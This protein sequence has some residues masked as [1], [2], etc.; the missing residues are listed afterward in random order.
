M[1]VHHLLLVASVAVGPSL[2]AATAAQE[3]AVSRLTDEDR[4]VVSAILDHSARA[5]GRK[6]SASRIP[7]SSP[8]VL[9][10]RTVMACDAA[11][12]GPRCFMPEWPRLLLTS[13]R[14]EVVALDLDTEI[15]QELVSGILQR[16]A[17]PYSLVTPFP[18]FTLASIGSREAPLRQ[19]RYAATPYLG[20]SAPGY[21]N[22]RSVAVIYAFHSCGLR[23]GEGWLY[24][25]DKSPVGWRVRAQL[26]LWIS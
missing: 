16:N 24:V 15:R 6:Y 7:A 18:E 14:P 3:A 5:H 25:I 8:M 12:T 11:R 17:V 19:E 26:G 10:D 22:D 21:S 9:L 20:V 23:C 1:R 13:T 4:R 2:A